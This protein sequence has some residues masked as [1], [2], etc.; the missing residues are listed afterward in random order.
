MAECK[1]VDENDTNEEQQSPSTESDP[2][3]ALLQRCRDLE[4]ENGRLVEELSCYKF[5]SENLILNAR[6]FHFYTGVTVDIFN[7][8]VVKMNTVKLTVSPVSLSDQILVTLVKIKTGCTNV[9]L[10]YKFGFTDCTVSRILRCII[11]AMAQRM[12]SFV[13]WPKP[14]SIRKLVPKRFRKEYKRVVCIID[15]TEIFIERPSS[16]NARAATYSQYKHHNT[17][18]FLIGCTLDGS[19]V[20]HLF[21]KLGVDESL[22]TIS[23][24]KV[25]FTVFKSRRCSTCGSG[26]YVDRIICVLWSQAGCAIIHK[27]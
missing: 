22:T 17:V 5:S 18:K 24:K 7:L 27:R 14:E 6:K 26:F 16:T 4:K 9:D 8:L 23:L 12:K 10:A 20:Y 25:A 13:A 2:C 1:D 19:I 21:R 3:E 11:P 15:C